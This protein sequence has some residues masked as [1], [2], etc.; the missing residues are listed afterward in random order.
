MTCLLAV[1]KFPNTLSGL[2]QWAILTVEIWCNGAR[3]SVNPDKTGLVA[4]ARKRNL[5]GLFEPQFLGIKLSLSGSVK[6]LGVILDYRLTWR[7]HVAVKVRKVHN[8]L[9]ACRRVCGAGWGLRP[10][11]VHWLY[12]AIVE[13]TISFAS[14]VWW[15]G[16]QTASTKKK[17][18]KVQRL[19]C[20]RITGTIR[21]SPTGAIK[22]L[23]GL[24]PLDLVIQREA[25]LAAHRL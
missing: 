23:A 6:Y 17:P 24:P 15:P 18:S 16:Y 10:K 13:P 5:Q 19:A 20:L 2:M 12:V 9:W 3:L 4:F 7:K 1:D 8:L 14:L 11:I 21:T 22:A 25:R